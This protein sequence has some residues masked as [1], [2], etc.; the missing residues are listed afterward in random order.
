MVFTFLV[1]ETRETNL[2]KNKNVNIDE[3][4]SICNGNEE[5]LETSLTGFKE[6]SRKLLGKVYR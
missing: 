4:C 3:R 6:T 2:P 1:S 5:Q